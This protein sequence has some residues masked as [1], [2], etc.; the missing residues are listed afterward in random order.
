M[1]APYRRGRMSAAGRSRPGA[2]DAAYKRDDKT[3]S[4]TVRADD[5][6]RPGHAS[7]EYSSIGSM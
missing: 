7:C 4:Y 5:R 2:S 3:L 1:A 6:T